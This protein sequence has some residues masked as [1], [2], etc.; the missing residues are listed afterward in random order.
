MTGRIGLVALVGVLGVGLV[1]CGGSKK[2]TGG[3]D[4]GAPD[5]TIMLTDSGGG[6]TDGGGDTDGGGG[7]T[8]AGGGTAMCPMGEC[9]LLDNGCASGQACYF[10]AAM[11]GGTPMPVCQ[12]AGTTAVGGNCM[13]YADC[14]AGSFCDARAAGMMGK[15]RKYCCGESDEGCPMGTSCSVQF[16]DAMGMPLGVGYCAG[17]DSCDPVEQTG[18]TGDE[19]CYLNG[20]SGAVICIESA[21][22]KMEGESCSAA[23]DCAPGMGCFS[24]MMGGSTNCVK[25]CDTMDMMPG[26]TGGKTCQAAGVPMQ[27]RL[28]VCVMPPAG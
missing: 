1:A 28:G 26:C 17:G 2:R 8:D 3:T 7:G 20:P 24:T 21:G 12:P 15:C 9:D 27:P 25:F 16:T 11:A 22:D 14:A 13:T 23:N 4:A 18:C 6:G 10:L 19:G 5:S